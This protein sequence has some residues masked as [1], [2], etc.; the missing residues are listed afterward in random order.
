MKSLWRTIVSV[1][2]EYGENQRRRFVFTIMHPTLLEMYCCKNQFLSNKQMCDQQIIHIHIIKLYLLAIHLHC[3][4]SAIKKR[5]RFEN[6]E[7][8]KL[9]P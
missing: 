6:I 1:R 2:P 3:F 8:L 4:V 5:V 9:Q 7:L